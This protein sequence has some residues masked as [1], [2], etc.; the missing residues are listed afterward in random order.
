VWLTN[1]QSGRLWIR[2]EKSGPGW[3][4]KKKKIRSSYR[5]DCKAQSL[6]SVAGYLTVLGFYKNIVVSVWYWTDWKSRK[7]KSMAEC[8]TFFRLY[9]K[10]CAFC[11]VLNWHRPEVKGRLFDSVDFLYKPCVIGMVL[12]WLKVQETEVN[13]RMLNIFEILRQ[14]CYRPGRPKW[15]SLTKRYGLMYLHPIWL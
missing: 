1:V 9:G 6:H 14:T 13:G 5:V 8:W 4:Y 2:Y 12:D 11:M 7:L 10:R 15:N 3:L